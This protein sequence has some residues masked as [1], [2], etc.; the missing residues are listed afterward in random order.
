[1]NKI[2]QL[3]PYVG[4]EELKYLEEVISNKWITEGPFTER[5]LEH[6]KAFTGAEYALLTNNGTLGL[7]LS[8]LG[9]G[10]GKGDEVI[11]PDFTF[12]ASASCV[13]FAGAKPVFV[14]VNEHDYHIKIEDIESVI[15]DKTKAIMPVNIYGQCADLDL[16]TSVAQ[17]YN[18]YVIED[19]AQGYGVYYKNKHV[20]TLGDVGVISFFADK[21][22][23][24]GEGAVIL[25]D[26]VEIYEKI[27]LL[28]NQGR[29]NSGSFIHPVLGMNFR[30][31]DIQCAV[32]L[33]QMNKYDE[34]LRLKNENLSIYKHFLKG[35]ANVEFMRELDYCNYV[36]FRCSIRVKSRDSL[37]QFL[38]E[39]G[40]QSRNYFY[41]LHLQPCFSELGY[42][43]GDF[44]VTNQ[45][46]G[47]GLMLPVF[48]G[49][50]EYEIEY[51]CE[52][53]LQFY[54]QQ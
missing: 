38:V 22:V 14:D 26:N 31:T 24:M 46:S 19:A 50:Q 33:A 30:V 48:P 10:I 53:I 54:S 39:Q 43:N 2:P 11:V 8:I 40:I 20:G 52:S 29:E 6:I 45:I 44:P 18:L 17:K 12:N 27:Q 1:M 25:T 42:K 32:G 28:R 21:T 9:L 13:A 47:D 51:I 49:L 35:N 41:P 4:E 36:P 16:I 37:S 5:V 7:F 3:I 23:T 34:I 15:T